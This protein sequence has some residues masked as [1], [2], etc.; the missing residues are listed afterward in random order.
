MN[1]QMLQ[2]KPLRDRSHTNPSTIDHESINK[3]LVSASVHGELERTR[4]A[5]QP[6]NTPP[7]ISAPVL[8]NRRL[9]SYVSPLH[10]RMESLELEYLSAKGALKIPETSIRNALLQSYY[11][12]VHPYM[13]LIDVNDFLHIVNEGTG[14]SGKVS[15]LLLQALMFTGTAFVEMKYL[16]AMGFTKRKAARKAFYEKCRVSFSFRVNTKLISG[17]L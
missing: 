9:P 1:N 15:L 3:L 2:S 11:C 4:L 12:W 5:P 6:T 13:P 10:P 7:E 14:A 17:P 16:N 8:F